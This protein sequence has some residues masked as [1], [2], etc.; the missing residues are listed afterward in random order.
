MSYRFNGASKDDNSNFIH[1]QSSYKLM[2]DNSQVPQPNQHSIATSIPTK[3][4]LFQWFYNLPISR[5]QLVGLFACE[6]LSILG[7]GIGA[8]LIIT[9]GARTQLLEQA[10]S[11]LTI[12]DINYNNKFNQMS[13]GAQQNSDNPAIL[14]AA[15][16][17]NSGQ[18]LSQDLQSEVQRILKNKAK[19]I[20]IEYATLVGKDLKIIDSSDFGRQGKFF[21][22]S[23][24]VREVFKNHQQIKANRTISRS[25]LNQYFPRLAASS[26]KQDCLV[27]Y[28]VTPVKDPSTKAVIAA[29]VVGN[30]V[31]GKDAIARETLQATGGGYSAV[32]LRKPSG[33]FTLATSLLQTQSEDFN[34]SQPNVELPPAGISLL[35]A[36]AEA[37]AGTTV[38]QRMVI[39]NQAYAMAAKALPNTIIEEADGPRV[40]DDTQPMAILV[41]GTPETTLNTLL[42][43]NLI[44]QA[45][46]IV[47]A[48]FLIAIWAVMFRRAI[49]KP[50]KNLLQTAQKF[51]TGDRSCRAEVFANDE[52]GQFAIDFNTMADRIIEQAHHQEREAKLALQINEITAHIRELFHSEKIL[53][54]A[55]SRTRDALQV[56]RVLFYYLDDHWQG[57]MIAESVEY[58]CSAAFGAKDS[59]PFLAEEYSDELQIGTV[60]VVDNIYE[61][62]FSHAYFQQLEALA[63]KAYLLAPVFFNK[64]LYGLLVAHQCSSDRSWRD[65][66]INLF[67]QIAIQ[68]GYALEQAELTQ[69]I[70]QGHRTTETVF[71]EEG[72][73]K[74][75]QQTT[76]LIELL[77]NVEG[78]ARGDLTVRADVSEGEIGT[79]ADFFNSI[80]ESLRDTIAK[81][82]V[83]AIQVNEAIGCNE[84][85]I[86]QLAQESLTQTTEISRIL[87]AV[88]Q[89]TSAMQAVAS[90]AQQAA[91]VANTATNTATKSEEAIDTTVENISHLR[92]VVGDT[93]KKVKRLGESTQEI[94]R[95][96]A[97]INQ[98]SMQTNLLAINAGI[99]AA[100]VGEEG[101]GFVVV[102]EEVGELAARSAQATKE[103]E[104]I[105]ENV[106]QETNEVVAA[107]QLGVTE[108]AKGMH[109]V[110]DAKHSL[111]QILEI[112]RQIDALVQSISTAT[113]YGVQTSQTVSE[114]M[115]QIAATSKHTSDSSVQVSKSLQQTVKIS[116]Q[117]KETVEIFKVN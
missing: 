38:A 60:K 59:D 8:I 108:V 28:T 15:I 55:V 11:E 45:F 69:Q 99:E 74:S 44:L 101:Q 116:Q 56:E 18:S 16:L 92:Q 10:K 54:T 17:H 31:N 4:S 110:E 88:D 49:I 58:S 20:K 114:L 40:V 73:Q 33:E 26:S 2:I 57:K 100:R 117:L 3:K 13:F 7:V 82:K 53:K 72:Q 84:T 23:N 83:S 93:A 85:A 39:G 67:K 62:N 107:M 37:S 25:E 34:Q 97:L 19:D 71:L 111:S 22:P 32:Y 14:Q 79:V 103:I 47:I 75:T 42:T 98:I 29:L 35:S 12:T 87:D 51:T 50:V 30:I 113:V 102:S 91:Q 63:V 86:R 115:K 70:E 21:N 36:A 77:D 90:S 46:I 112:S 68:T 27:R 89:M 95:V 78:A 106:Q 64:K 6:L 76:Q 9:Q 96:V 1:S 109:I 80:V 66:E 81:V 61:N 41:R 24:L 65:T 48:A 5:K 94:S 104:E 43:H 52:I 105:V